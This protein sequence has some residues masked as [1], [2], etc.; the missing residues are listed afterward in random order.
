MPRL[1]S[2]EKVLDVVRG[3]AVLVDVLLA[4]PSA[5][6]SHA[7]QILCRVSCRAAFIANQRGLT[8]GRLCRE[9]RE[10]TL[11]QRLVQVEGATLALVGID[12]SRRTSLRLWPFCRTWRA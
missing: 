1:N 4:G 3:V 5:Q 12:E 11:C 7:W 10:S 8:A 2:A 9:F 6:R